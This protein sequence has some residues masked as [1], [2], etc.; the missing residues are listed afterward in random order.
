M[1]I[2][3]RLHGLTWNLAQMKVQLVSPPPS[4]IY[5]KWNINFKEIQEVQ[6]IGT[7]AENER[8]NEIIS[9]IPSNALYIK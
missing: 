6:R 4:P 8:L 5:Y 2:V 9:M 3:W 1:K 7:L